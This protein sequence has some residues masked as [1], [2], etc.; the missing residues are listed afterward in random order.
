[1]RRGLAFAAGAYLCWGLLSPGNEIL[2]RQVTP[3]WMQAIRSIIAAVA[4]A[5]WLGPRGLRGAWQALGHRR[6][7]WGIFYGTFV[8][9]TC[10]VLAQDRIPATFATLGFYTAPLWTAI[11]GRW[12]LGER[13]GVWFLPAVLAMGIGA[14]AA[15]TGGGALPWP[16]PVGVGL[17]IGAGMAWAVFAVYLRRSSAEV[18]WKD[19]L[20]ASMLMAVP[21]F[22]L[23]AAV[24][25]PLPSLAD[26]TAVTWR[27]TFI[28]V[29]VPTL[30][31]MG[32]F[33]L[34]LRHAPASQVNI[35]VGL[36]LLGT[37]VLAAILLDAR[38][39]PIQLG[40]LALAMVAVTGYLWS[41]DTTAA[42]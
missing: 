4:L 28:Q 41:M 23:I 7:R 2:L 32:L 39:T 33:Q 25:E 38:F 6:L 19:L 30:L 21:L 36:E 40:G 37:V 18:P 31:A 16:D 24:F 26:W 10:F 5:A 27:W 12:W 1:M 35:L 20:L 9:F 34:G 15:L 13:I 17:A 14:W 22:L 8:S 11:L 3:L 29:A 42:T